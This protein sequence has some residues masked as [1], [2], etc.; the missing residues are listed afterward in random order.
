MGKNPFS[1]RRT[2]SRRRNLRK[3]PVVINPPENSGI[4]IVPTSKNDDVAGTSSAGMSKGKKKL[5]GARL[6]MK[7]DKF[8][9]SELIEWDKSSIIKRVGIPAR[10]LRILGPVFSHSSNILARERAMVV[11]LEFIKAIVTAEEVLLLDPLRQ[12]VLPFV[13]QLRQQLP[14]K[15][16]VMSKAGPIYDGDSKLGSTEAQWA[17]TPEAVEGEQ[18]ELPFEFQVLEIALEV[19]CSY[20]N[21][22]VVEL[23][24]HAYPVLDEL[25]RNVSTKNLERVRSLKSNLTHLLARVQKVRDEI[26]HLLDDNEDMA[27]LYL[28]R[29]LIQYQQSEGLLNLATSNAIV[30]QH[31]LHRNSSYRSGSIMTSNYWDDDVEDLEMLLEAYFMQLDGTRNRI[32]SVRE[33]IDDT[34]DYVNIQLDN[35]RNE[36]IQLQLHLTIASFAIAIDTLIAGFF[37]MNIP[38]SLY[39][40]DGV[41]GYVVAGGIVFSFLMY[42]LILGY[43]RWKKLLGS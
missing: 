34:E 43:A 32:L 40:K 9:E 31:F 13:E 14:H 17:R 6:W 28:T 15:S 3:V 21:S 41:F 4:E 27:H 36:L 19:V 5:G 2:L 42:L 8:G 26:E 30:P 22:N 23:E 1:F 12:E 29:K 24:K 35:Q 20:L 38:C 39:T 37:G 10:D 7:F 11:N 33:Y 18:Q 25:A 16:Q